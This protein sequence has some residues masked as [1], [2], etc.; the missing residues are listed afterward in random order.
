MQTQF[1]L[2][3]NE[4]QTIECLISLFRWLNDPNSEVHGL[5]NEGLIPVLEV[6]LRTNV[7]SIQIQAAK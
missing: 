4:K 1:S 2:I 6:C 3:Q 7:N 5:L